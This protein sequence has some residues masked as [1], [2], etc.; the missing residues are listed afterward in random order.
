MSARVQSALRASAAGPAPA[1]AGARPVQAA[2]LPTSVDAAIGTTGEPLDVNVRERMGH[3]LGHDLSRVRV[4]HDGFAARASR[5]VGALAFTLGDHVVFGAGRYAPSTPMGSELLAHELVHVAQ[6][7]QGLSRACDACAGAGAAG[8]SRP[9]DPSELE[10]DALASRVARGQSVRVN[11]HRAPLLRRT[12]DATPRRQMSPTSQPARALL[13]HLHGN[14][15]NAA[16]LAADMFRLRCVNFVD[17]TRPATITTPQREVNVTDGTNTIAVDPNR[18]FTPTGRAAVVSSGVS[19]LGLPNAAA[20][21][22]AT[23]SLRAELDTFA[24]TLVNEIGLG[25]G[26]PGSSLVGPL[27][28]VALHNNDPGD[29]RRAFA[30]R[31]RPPTRPGLS[32]RWY[33]QNDPLQPSGYSPPERHA[34]DSGTPGAPTAGVAPHLASRQSEED[35]FLTTR[36]SDFDALATGNVT[37]GSERNVVLQGTGAPDDGSLSIAVQRE[38]TAAA[39]AGTLPTGTTQAQAERYFNIEAGGKRP[40]ARVV[41]T[42]RSMIDDA[43]DLVGAGLRANG[44]SVPAGATRTMAPTS[45]VGTTAVSGNNPVRPVGF[46]SA[47]SQVVGAVVQRIV[48]YATRPAPVAPQ[49][50][51]AWSEDC[52]TYATSAELDSRKQG[53]ATTIAEMPVGEVVAWITGF[54]SGPVFDDARAESG[55]QVLCMLR[56]MRASGAVS[57][58]PASAP[59]L[60]SRAWIQS[61]MR[62]FADQQAIWDCK[63]RF[64]DPSA[65]RRC[66]TRFGRIT[67][68]AVRACPTAGLSVGGEWVRGAAH[69]PCW[70]SL[71]NDQKQREI[72]TTSSAPG[73]SRHHQ[74]TEFDLLSTTPRDFE[75]GQ[76]FASAYQWLQAN[77][78][79]FGFI[80]SFE[81]EATFMALGY[82]EERWHWSY[83]PIAQALLEFARNHLTDIETRLLA[84]WGTAPEF[85]F[86]RDHWQEF[87]F[88]VHQ[89]PTSPATVPGGTGTTPGA[90]PPGVTGTPSPARPARAHP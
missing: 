61:G 30:P 45:R 39:A 48:E 24:T 66:V 7:A 76:T 23:T 86:I 65:D 15:E 31:A 77:A 18:I 27:P 25:R 38:A 14:E 57:N 88:N 90:V 34:T 9:D 4:H 44:C 33:L 70:T 64:R 67:P 60:G 51:P 28:V 10:A 26:G 71:S 58:L 68:E 62:D 22:A 78:V 32:I 73:I 81:P 21:T 89:T 8:M 35:F 16:S 54:G 85:S 56:A 12:V 1:P 5:D 59:S 63:F 36:R 53:W 55:Q 43:L 46:A 29:A 69:R 52:R 72:L 41:A 47:I 11:E 20:R 49:A 87:L 83:Y 37:H 19:G 82:T 13:V 80:Q 50:I 3:A 40:S 6:G 17:L 75:A 74:G 42:Q 2:P 79:A 84:A